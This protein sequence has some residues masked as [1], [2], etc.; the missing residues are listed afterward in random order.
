[1]YGIH[2][3]W[4][5]IRGQEETVKELGCAIQAASRTE[6]GCV[7]YIV[8]QDIEDPAVF[9]LYEQY[10]D[11]AAFQAHVASEHFQ[12]IV[13]EQIRPLLAERSRNLLQP[14]D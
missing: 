9:V 3:M 1:M 2:A 7:M 6:P 11:E 10:V 13:M 12:A 5:A 4:R 14:L 8:N